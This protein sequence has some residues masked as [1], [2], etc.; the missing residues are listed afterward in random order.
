MKVKLAPNPECWNREA[1]EAHAARLR[2]I[3]KI[4]KGTPGCSVH[5]G[6]IACSGCDTSPVTG[7]KLCTAKH[8]PLEVITDTNTPYP[9]IRDTS[10][11]PGFREIGPPPT[12]PPA[13][14]LPTSRPEDAS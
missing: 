9:N 4:A 1:I 6:E 7:T 13:I 2:R 5:I 3:E 8:D 11:I 12:T 14:N 10:H